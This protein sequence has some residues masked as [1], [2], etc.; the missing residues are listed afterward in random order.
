VDDEAAFQEEI[1]KAYA[2]NNIPESEIPDW[3]SNGEPMPPCLSEGYGGCPSEEFFCGT[4][5]KD[6]GCTSSPYK[7][8]NPSMKTGAVAGFTILG[9]AVFATVA[10]V[11]HMRSIKKQK[12]RL[13]KVFARQV[14]KRVDLRGSVSQLNPN[15]LASEFKRIDKGIKEGGSA[16]G[17]I[18]KEE[19]WDFVQSGKAGDISEKDFDALFE[20]MD[21]QNRGK[22]NF[23][24]FAGFMSECADEVREI[25]KETPKNTGRMSPE[26][27]LQAASLRLSTIKMTIPA[28]FEDD[29]TV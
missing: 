13:R 27:R 29:E 6:P 28:D 21:I 25:A 14:A 20:A 9:L 24:E 18:S 3:V 19:L 22:V 11:F 15:D 17:Y 2:N 26:E 16:D 4:D 1:R 5:G 23:V 7:E 8:T 12:K 10:Y